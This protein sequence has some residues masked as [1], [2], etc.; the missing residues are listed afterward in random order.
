MLL[1]AQIMPVRAEELDLVGVSGWEHNHR[2]SQTLG[3]LRLKTD[4]LES[5]QN[6]P[7]IFVPLFALSKSLMPFATVQLA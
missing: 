6:S 1:A 3:L 5:L 2:R 4:F 7:L